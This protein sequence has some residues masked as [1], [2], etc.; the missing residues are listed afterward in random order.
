M[1]NINPGSEEYALSFYD[2][3]TAID[4][5]QN[6]QSTILGGDIMSEYNNELIYAYQ[7]WGSEYHTLNWAFQKKDDDASCYM[8]SIQLAIDSI[9]IANAIADRLKKK[10]YFVLIVEK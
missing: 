5:L 2:V 4:I 6:S 3:L 8:K 9:K 7:L 1:S 10:S